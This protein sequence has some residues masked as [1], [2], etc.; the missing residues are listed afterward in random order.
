MPDSDYFRHSFPSFII[1]LPAL[2]HCQADISF[3]YF[4]FGDCWYHDTC[5]A[6]CFFTC[7]YI[8]S[9]W[10]FCHCHYLFSFSYFIISLSF[11]CMIILLFWPLFL[12]FYFFLSPLAVMFSPLF[13]SPFADAARLSALSLF[14][15]T[16]YFHAATDYWCFFF[17]FWLRFSFDSRFRFVI[18]SFR[19]YFL[20]FF[21]FSGASAIAYAFSDADLPLFYADIRFI[22]HFSLSLFM[23]L[24]CL[25]FCFWAHAAIDIDDILNY[26]ISSHIS[27]NI[28]SYHHSHMNFHLP[29]YQ[30]Q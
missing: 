1:S 5:F 30:Q 26:I 7:W 20:Y 22:C 16:D 27:L 28:V 23:M 2:R 19:R 8:F 15:I 13:Y 9:L 29:E 3:H 24:R 18:S 21:F 6:F 12:L 25:L 4:I 10:L 14:M 11:H 17:F